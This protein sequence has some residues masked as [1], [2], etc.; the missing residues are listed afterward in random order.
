MPSSAL[1]GQAVQGLIDG[2]MVPTQLVMFQ[3]L[4]ACGL[5][6]DTPSL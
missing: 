3:S 1:D 4:R 6:C 2:T 5:V